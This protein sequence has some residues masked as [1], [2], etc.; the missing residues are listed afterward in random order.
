MARRKLT[1]AEAGRMGGLARADNTTPAERSAISSKAGT[2]NVEA[3]GRAHMA[4]LAYKRW[5]RL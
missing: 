3:H 2:A 5:G 1:R 4:R